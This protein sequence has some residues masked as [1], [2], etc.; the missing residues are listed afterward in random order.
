MVEKVESDRI[1]RKVAEEWRNRL[2]ERANELERGLKRAEEE[3]RRHFLDRL[4]KQI[5]T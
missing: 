2:N 3:S 4:L 1:G 5:A